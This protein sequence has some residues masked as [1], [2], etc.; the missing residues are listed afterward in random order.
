MKKIK[1]EICIQYILFLVYL[2]N[3]R[4]RVTI[5]LVQLRNTY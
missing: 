3:K 2:Y 4:M 1:Y 5:Q